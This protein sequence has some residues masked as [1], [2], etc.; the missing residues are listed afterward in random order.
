PELA[1]RCIELVVSCT[2]SSLQQLMNSDVKQTVAELLIYFNRNPT[3]VMRSFQKSLLQS[4]VD[5]ELSSQAA[6]AE[7]AAFIAER[8]LGVITHF[9]GCLSEPTF[10]K[11]LKEETLY[12]LGQIM[13]FVGAQHVTQF[14]FKI[15]AMLSFVHTLQE[16]RLLRICLKIWNIFLHV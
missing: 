12:S 15:I 10:E 8:F 4:S 1:N 9:E 6:N 7:F 2:Q 13:R 11:Q 5:E 14:R 3:F 16:P